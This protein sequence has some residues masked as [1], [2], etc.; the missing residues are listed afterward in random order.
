MEYTISIHLIWFVRLQNP[1]L[2][3]DR[4]KGSGAQVGRNPDWRWA[5]DS[6]RREGHWMAMS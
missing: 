3:Q 4:G 1:A 5:E 6:G 2:W